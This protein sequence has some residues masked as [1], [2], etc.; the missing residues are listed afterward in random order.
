MGE[1]VDAP[2]VLLAMMVLAMLRMLVPP[3]PLSLKMPPPFPA[4]LPERVEL[5]MVRVPPP[6]G[7]P[8][9][10]L[11]IPPP[12]PFVAVLPERVELVMVRVPPPP[13]LMAPPL[14]GEVLPERVELLMVRVPKLEMPPPPLK[15]PVLLLL[16]R[17]ELVMVRLLLWPLRMPPP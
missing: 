1:G 10:P 16:E 7:P 13:L 15:P 2:L 14:A 3:K 4:L 8:P 9:G 11:Q 6:P 5:V 17:V 12:L